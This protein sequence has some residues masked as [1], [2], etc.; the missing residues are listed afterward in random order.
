MPLRFGFAPENDWCDLELHQLFHDSYR[1]IFTIHN[2]QVYILHIRHGA[3]QY[4]SRKELKDDA[5]SLSE[6]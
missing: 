1:I 5:S 3:R 6:D 4:L 2:E